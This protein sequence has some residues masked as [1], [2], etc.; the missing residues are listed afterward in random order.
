MHKMPVFEALN[1]EKC[2]N[3]K[4]AKEIVKIVLQ[5]DTAGKCSL[6]MLKLFVQ[7]NSH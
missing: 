5:H 7:T 6:M 2:G 4:V 1:V 3:S